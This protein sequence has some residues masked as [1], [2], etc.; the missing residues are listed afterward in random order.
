MADTTLERLRHVFA[1]LPETTERASAGAPCFYVRTRAVCRYHRA[2]FHHEGSRPALWCRSPDGVP[3]E[4]VAADAE[5]FFRPTPSASGVFAGWLGVYLDDVVGDP[6]DWDE[7][8]GIL[9]DAYR[10]SAP[11]T[12]SRLLDG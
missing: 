7:V 12:L 10:L 1:T 6:V 9:V 4:L 8:R 2:G 3:E 5:R 11:K